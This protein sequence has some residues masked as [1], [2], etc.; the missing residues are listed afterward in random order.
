MQS[1]GKLVERWHQ[2]KANK[3]RGTGPIESS[4]IHFSSDVLLL[5]DANGAGFYLSELFT[6]AIKRGPHN[7]TAEIAAEW[8]MEIAEEIYP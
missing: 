3:N 5:G 6:E 7:D 2:L 1:D 8:L 4:Q